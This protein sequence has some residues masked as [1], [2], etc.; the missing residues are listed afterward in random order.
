[1]AQATDSVFVDMRLLKY[2]SAFEQA[3]FIRLSDKGQFDALNFLFCLDSNTTPEKAEKLK[4]KLNSF[5]DEKFGSISGDKNSEKALKLIFKG[6]HDGLLTKYV[7]NVQFDRLLDAGE[8]NCVTASALYALAFARFHIPYQIRSTTD[9]VYVIANPG[10]QQMMIETTDPV[11]GAFQYSE[12]Y[13]KAYIESQVKQKMISREEY[14]SSSVSTL[15]QKYFFSSDTI[16]LKALIGYHYYNNGITLLTKENYE[17]CVNQLMK[18]FCLNHSKQVEHLLAVSLQI[19]LNKNFDLTDSADISKF[20]LLSR[21]TGESEERFL[22]ERYNDLSEEL[23]IRKDDLQRYDAISTYLFSQITD[24]E[25]LSKLKEH[26]YFTK[27]TNYA[28]KSNYLMAY[29]NILEGYCLNNKDIRIKALYTRLDDVAFY[30][31]TDATEKKT[32]DSLILLLETKARTCAA[33]DSNK[34]KFRLTL[35]KASKMFE[36]KKLEKGEQFLQEAEGIA[37]KAKFDEADH[38]SISIAYNAAQKIYYLQ[39]NIPKAKEYVKRGLKLDPEN[40]GLKTD[41]ET[42]EKLGDV[43]P[44]KANNSANK[45]GPPPPPL[46]PPASNVKPRTIIVKSGVK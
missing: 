18:A 8:Y 34:L 41:L 24:N 21:L 16:D 36:S 17:D 35:I 37:A 25:Q 43:S 28:I 11:N 45:S 38:N 40:E 1:M 31:L 7:T 23:S 14:N 10:P 30:L 15:F 4:L 2:S 33:L 39:Y 5:L 3:Q 27:A 12:A 46:P 9:H 32:G 42:L 13:K 26:Y 19:A 20:F 29:K 6:I 22:Y 44:A